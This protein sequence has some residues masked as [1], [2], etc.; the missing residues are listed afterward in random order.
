MLRVNVSDMSA[1]SAD[2]WV[3][4][5]IFG[6][7]TRQEH[8]LLVVFRAQLRDLHE[9]MLHDYVNQPPFVFPRSKWVESQIASPI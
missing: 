4:C 1:E 2:F 5:V 8:T 7:K 9:T 3:F 6:V